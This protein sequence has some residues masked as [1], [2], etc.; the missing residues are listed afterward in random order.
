VVHGGHSRP[1]APA[2]LASRIE[3]ARRLSVAAPSATS[4]FRIDATLRPRQ[5]TSNEDAGGEVTADRF[6]RWVTEAQDRQAVAE[7]R[8]EIVQ[9]PASV[10]AIKVGRKGA[11]LWPVKRRPSNCAPPRSVRIDLFGRAAIGTYDGFVD[12]DVEVGMVRGTYLRRGDATVGEALRSVGNLT[13]ACDAPRVGRSGSIKTHARRDRRA[14][15][16]ELFNGCAA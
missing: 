5:T 9:V 8:G 1:M 3:R 13:S 14:T 11:T 7:R 16:D 4:L 6:G 2:L 10:S 15:A 12:V